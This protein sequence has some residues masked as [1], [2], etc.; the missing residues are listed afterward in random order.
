MIRV[1]LLCAFLVAYASLYPWRFDEGRH[2]GNPLLILLRSWHI[3]LTISNAKDV[4]VNL[5]VYMPLGFSGY[6]GF[7]GIRSKGLRLVLPVALSLVLSAS[8]EMLQIYDST[9]YCS[10][11]DVICNTAG[12]FAGAIAAALLL[13]LMPKLKVVSALRAEGTAPILLLACWAAYQAMTVLPN[14]RLEVSSELTS[15]TTLLFAINALGYALEWL[16]AGKILET[17]VGFSRARWCLALLT[18]LLPFKFLIGRHRIYWAEVVGVVFAFA[19]WSALAKRRD[20]PHTPIALLFCLLLVLR[21]L[22]P[23][24][25]MPFS[26]GFNWIPFDALFDTERQTGLV[27]LTRK[28]FDYAALIWLLTRSRVPLWTA[29]AAVAVALG[30][31]EALQTHIPGR[32]AEIT[33]PLLALLCALMLSSLRLKS[34]SGLPLGKARPPARRLRTPL[35]PS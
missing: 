18:L 22:A 3:Q 24:R 12:A 21:G 11:I 35:T 8:I 1:F 29:A 9:R 32:S 28:V 7:N 17:V 30:L 15:P 33:D 20:F 34:S 4:V 13:S 14:V 2:L 5:L 27:I 10:L 6:W 16:I 26:H 19:V 23:F 25:F 31:V